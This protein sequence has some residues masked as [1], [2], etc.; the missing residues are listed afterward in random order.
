M[1]H[2]RRTTGN[3]DNSERRIPISELRN[4]GRDSAPTGL[5]VGA[6]SLPRWRVLRSAFSALRSAFPGISIVSPR[7]RTVVAALLFLNL[8]ACRHAGDRPQ[9]KAAEPFRVHAEGVSPKRAESLATTAWP[10][11]VQTE[12]ADLDGD[13]TPDTLCLYEQATDLPATSE[14]VLNQHIRLTIHTRRGSFTVVDE[15]W[16]VD[17]K[18]SV[19]LSD[20]RRPPIFGVGESGAGEFSWFQWDGKTYRAA[21]ASEPGLE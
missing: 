21:S 7:F 5:I 19:L 20:T 13:G 12:V 15:D 2:N 6:E 8:A 16:A 9:K 3:S 4:R 17:G 11:P 1:R 18:V 10:Q 14:D